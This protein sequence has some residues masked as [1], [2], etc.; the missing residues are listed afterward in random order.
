[1]P[2]HGQTNAGLN[3][4]MASNPWGMQPLA[5]SGQRGVRVEESTV[6]TYSVSTN[7]R[8]AGLGESVG[9]LRY[10]SND[11]LVAKRQGNKASWDVRLLIETIDWRGIFIYFQLGLGRR[12]WVRLPLMVQYCLSLANIRQLHFDFCIGCRGSRCRFPR[13]A[14]GHREVEYLRQSCMTAR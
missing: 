3:T 8:N 9:R 11:L 7:R 5:V 2:T 1:M 14:V 12:T 13:Q 4:R 6:G 10:V